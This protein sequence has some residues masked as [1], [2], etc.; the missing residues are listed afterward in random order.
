MSLLR[1]RMMSGKTRTYVDIYNRL[2]PSGGLVTNR[3]TFFLYLK[4]SCPV[5]T[6]IHLAMTFTAIDEGV[7]SLQ[8]KAGAAAVAYITIPMPQYSIDVEFE[9]TQQGTNTL[10][11]YFDKDV[12]DVQIDKASIKVEKII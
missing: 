12:T 5:G 4:E 6:K 2:Y 3:N 9:M 7:T 10:W 11:C 8:V 1:R